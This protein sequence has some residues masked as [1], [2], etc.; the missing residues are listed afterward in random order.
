MHG[1]KGTSPPVRGETQSIVGA[2]AYRSGSKLEDKRL[3]I[4]HDFTGKAAKGVISSEIMTPDN[5][6][7]WMKDR[8]HL[9]N[10]VEQKEDK[11]SKLARGNP[12]LAREVEISLPVELSPE[13][14]Q[15]MVREFAGDFVSQGMVADYSIHEPKLNG[16]GERNPHAHILLTMRDIDGDGFGKKNRSWNSWDGTRRGSGESV[17]RLRE[18]WADICNR[19]LEAAGASDRIDHRSFERQGIT[20]RLPSV[21]QGIQATAM[22]QRG[23]PT[24]RGDKQRIRAVENAGLE[25]D[26]DEATLKT[27][28]H[29]DTELHAYRTAESERKKG[30]TRSAPAWKYEPASWQD[31]E[32]ERRQ[33]RARE[34][35][36]DL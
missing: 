30:L 32:T 36:P 15:E 3:E 2:A 20:D 17:E 6:P 9:W 21:H 29:E 26:A 13:K 16:Q 5:A 27:S 7:D 25:Q 33:E 12:Q 4:T 1:A 19:E 11:A 24:R 35:E 10:A 14:H 23:E 8:E 34:L 28:D 22:Q 31:K 18:R